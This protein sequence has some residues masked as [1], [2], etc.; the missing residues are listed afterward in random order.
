MRYISPI[1]REALRGRI[2]TKFG[3]DVIIQS[4]FGLKFK[5]FRGFR[6][7]DGQNFSFPITLLVIVTTVLSRSL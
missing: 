5:H 6:F 3:I 2:C 4:S 1:C 7:T